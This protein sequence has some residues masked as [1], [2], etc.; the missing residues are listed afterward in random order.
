MLEIIKDGLVLARHIKKEDIRS[1]LNFFSNDN[2]FIQV[3]TWNYEAGKVLDRH[4]HNVVKREIDRTFE[5]I[6]VIQGKIQADIYDLNNILVKSI[7]VNEGETLVQL[8]SG[9][10]YK[11]LK[12]DTLVVEVKNGPYLGAELDRTR[13]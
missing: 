2:E 8:N 5:V 6:I 7:E 11:I 13:F 9:H 12:D 1:N 10:G 4:Y 3:G